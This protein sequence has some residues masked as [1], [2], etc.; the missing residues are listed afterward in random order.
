MTYAS[1]CGNTGSLT[2]WA[3]PG[4]EPTSSQI[5]VGSL[6]HRA[7]TGTS[8]LFFSEMLHLPS[9]ITLSSQHALLQF[10]FTQL[11]LTHSYSGKM[12]SFSSRHNVT[13]PTCSFPY[14]S[15]IWY[16]S[17]FSLLFVTC[18]QQSDLCMEFLDV[19]GFFQNEIFALETV[20]YSF[21]IQ[22]INVACAC[23][24]THTHTHF[25]V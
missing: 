9:I 6:I 15:I 10:P 2:H 23:T 14:L 13:I 7:T 22:L 3:R 17:A 24:H 12:T 21:R 16:S 8:V 5:L 19:W 11:T 18:F 25:L 20:D 4:T 1:A